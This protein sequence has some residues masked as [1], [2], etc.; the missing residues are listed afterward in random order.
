MLNT[1]HKIKH[2]ELLITALENKIE[3]L[4]DAEL[5]SDYA[6]MSIISSMKHTIF[7]IINRIQFLRNN[8]EK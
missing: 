8:D 1:E 4:V 7:L 3:V 6:G 2:L 5:D